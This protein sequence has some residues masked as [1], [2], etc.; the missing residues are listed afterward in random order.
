LISDSI[1]TNESKRSKAMLDL[2]NDELN[3]VS[4]FRVTKDG[5]EQ[6]MEF[7]NLDDLRTAIING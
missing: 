7:W 1:L 5:L 3:K 4:V 2:M 6:P